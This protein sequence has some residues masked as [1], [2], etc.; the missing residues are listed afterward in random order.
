MNT[1]L[2]IILFIPLVEIYLFIQIGGQIGAFNTILV[3]LLTAV[4]GVYFARLQGLSTL[5]SGITQLYSN[6]IPVYEMMSGA[7][8]TLAALLLIIPGFATDIIGF[9]LIIPVTRNIFFKFLSKKYTKQKS[10]N[11]K[12]KDDLIEGEYEDKDN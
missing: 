7:A 8:L 9:L 2:L 4:V 1:L 12:A 3:I 6:Q 5:K 11:E 10:A